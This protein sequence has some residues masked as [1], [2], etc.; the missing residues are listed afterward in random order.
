MIYFLM[1]KQHAYTLQDVCQHAGA[2]TTEIVHYEQLLAHLG[3]GN[4]LPPGTYVFTDIDRLPLAKLLQVSTIYQHLRD[5][6]ESCRVLNNPARV[7][8]RYGL[9][10]ELFNKG[11]NSFNVFRLD[12]GVFPSKYPVFIRYESEHAEPLSDLLASQAELEKAI[13]QALENGAP[14]SSILIV[15]YCAE[16]VEEGIYR[17]LATFRIGKQIVP[18]TMVQEDRWCVKY[19]TKGLS[20][21]EHFQYELD[22]VEGDGYGEEL[23]KVFDIANIDYGRADFA[24]VNGRV[25]IY[26]INTN[27]VVSF[28]PSHKSPIREQA[29]RVAWERYLA[30]LKSLGE[31]LQ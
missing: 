20:R 14:A 18:S 24:I 13:D 25:E 2:L 23:R 7:K 1:T 9:L 26:E 12:E 6:P 17:R 5:H 22:Y 28:P 15:E 31:S 10:R 11:I 8:G 21:D 27:P 19:G 30:A 3:A 4:N 16:P 29:M